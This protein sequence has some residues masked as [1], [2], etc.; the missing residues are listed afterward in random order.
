[1]QAVGRLLLAPIFLISGVGKIAAPG[2]MIGYIE[3]AGLPLPELALWLAVVFEIGGGLLLVFG[4]QTRRAAIALLVFTFVATFG[5]HTNF[6]DQNEMVM[7]LKNL[8]IIGGLLQV[9]A[10]GAG[11]YSLDS[12]RGGSAA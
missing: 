4:Y 10:F 12:R 7:F 8:A 2:A 3:S 5:F 9:I 1:M 6:A 11:A